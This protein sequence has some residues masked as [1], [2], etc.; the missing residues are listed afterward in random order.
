M[1][2]DTATGV[3]MNGGWIDPQRAM[4][5]VAGFAGSVIALFVRPDLGR[6]D[7]LGIVITGLIFAYFGTGYL[8]GFLPPG[9]GVRG[10]AGVICGSFGFFVAGR[11]IGF[12]RRGR[13]PI[14]GKEGRDEP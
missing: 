11:A 4:D 3:A 10:V 13:L 8:S 5:L 9:D 12:A 1:E 2:L 6:W 14:I 7:A